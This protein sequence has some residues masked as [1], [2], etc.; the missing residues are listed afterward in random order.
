MDTF[1][2]TATVQPMGE[3]RVAGVPFSAGTEVDVIICPKRMSANQFR[4]AWEQ[5][6]QH[7]R[8]LPQMQAIGDDEIQAEIAAHR[9]GR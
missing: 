6:C 4:T 1:E 5:V 9:A 7:L 8:G 2:I 3:V